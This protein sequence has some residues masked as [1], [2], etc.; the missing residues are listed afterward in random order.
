MLDDV[1][2]EV[3]L[4]DFMIFSSAAVDPNAEL[5]PITGF[6]VGLDSEFVEAIVEAATSCLLES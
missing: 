5:S 3:S 6:P 1:E 2:Q 4:V